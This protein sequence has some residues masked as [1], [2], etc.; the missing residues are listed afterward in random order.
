MGLWACGSVFGGGTSDVMGSK[1]A[2]KTFSTEFFDYWQIP[3]ESGVFRLDPP[4]GKLSRKQLSRNNAFLR[5]LCNRK[6]DLG[7]SRK[8]PFS[9]GN[10]TV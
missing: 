9:T 1:T 10:S 2:C 5:L 7:F 3:S 8:R 6:P 4:V